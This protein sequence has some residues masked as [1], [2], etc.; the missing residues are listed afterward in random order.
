[1]SRSPA[2]ITLIKAETYHGR[3]GEIDNAFR[4]RFDAL[5]VPVSRPAVS[6][7]R[8]L[9][10][11]RKGLF[12]FMPTDHGDGGDLKSYVRKIAQDHGFDRYCDGEITLI[13]QPRFL[14]YVFNPVSFWMFQDRNG[15]LRVVLAE[16]N[17]TFGERHT[18]LCHHE[19]FAPI[20]AK[21]RL[22]ARK[23]FH[24]S[25]FQDVAGRYTFRFR[26]NDGYVGIW[27]DL[28]HGNQGVF[29]SMTGNFET[30]NATSLIKSAV[31][32]PF[33]ALRVMALIHWQALKLKIKGGRYRRLPEQNPQRISR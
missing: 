11:G 13:A 30:V 6:P 29:A 16:V 15:D 9:S 28:R 17:N 22:T 31:T 19:D 33:G 8:L 10:V 24:V 23:I 32:R 25:P 21:D 27:I 20:H 18:Y 4:Y 3:H 26:L 1:M 7:S 5:R 2:D 12:S 14:G